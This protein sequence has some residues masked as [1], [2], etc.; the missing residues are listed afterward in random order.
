LDREDLNG[1]DTVF[2][3][4]YG[5][6]SNRADGELMERALLEAGYQVIRDRT[7]ADFLIYNT[8]AVKTPTENRMI[9]LLKNIENPERL[10]ITGCLPAINLKRLK[11]EIECAAIAGP[12]TGSQI[13]QIL[14]TV[15]RGSK[16]VAVD[17]QQGLEPL[18]PSPHPGRLISIVPVS[19]GCLGHCRYCCVKAARGE[20]RSHSV[21][22][23]GERVT[24]DIEGGSKEIWLTGQDLGCYGR[25]IG[26]T[27]PELLDRISK[28]EGEFRVRVG[29]MNPQHISRIEEELIDSFRSD[30]I[31]KFLHIPVQSG[32]DRILEEMG[33]VYS[34]EEFK[35][36]VS[37]FREKME[38]ITIATDVICGFPGEDREAFENT[39]RLLKEIRPDVLNI[40]RFFPR[41][42]TPKQEGERVSAQEKK[43]RSRRLTE[44]FRE[45]ALT[46]NRRWIGWEGEALIDE[47]REDGVSI[48]RNFAYRPIVINGADDSLGRYLKIRVYEAGTYHL[49][50]RELTQ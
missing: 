26:T 43:R 39:Y 22:E 23:I 15:K 21:D 45:I 3:E 27:L 5:C 13:V 16:W 35:R 14:E 9:Y 4:S 18:L 33:R 7:S 11:E 38:K 40:S 8:C 41:P 44:L 20:L 19:Y 46:Q 49:L 32:D 47:T 12:S 25:D 10:V 37:R 50:G 24:K 31:F 34:T 17:C 28:I 2:I 6:P 36:I 1:R 42:K 48:G 30:K 29:M